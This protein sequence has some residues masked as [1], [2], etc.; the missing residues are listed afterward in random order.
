MCET[1]HSNLTFT[2]VEQKL[3][4]NTLRQTLDTVILLKTAYFKHFQHFPANEIF[5][6]IK[7][8]ANKLEYV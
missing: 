1:G 6:T 2:T 8:A 7:F 5:E 3:H 4:W